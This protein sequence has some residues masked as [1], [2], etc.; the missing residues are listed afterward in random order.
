MATTLAD[1]AS[2]CKQTNRPF[3]SPGSR[4]QWDSLPVTTLRQPASAELREMGETLEDWFHTYLHLWL[5]LYP[6]AIQREAEGLTCK[7]IYC[8]MP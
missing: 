5:S 1:Y 3:V 6:L 2:V 7:Q 8:E 4:V